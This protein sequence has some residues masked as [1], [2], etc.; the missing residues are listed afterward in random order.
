MRAPHVPSS[1]FATPLD[2]LLGA[3]LRVRV[4]RSLDEANDVRR[5]SDLA[6]LASADPTAVQRALVPLIA[7]GLVEQVGRGR[8]AVYR[9]R[10]DHP[11]AP[12][13]RAL[14]AAERGRR[15]AVPRAV[16]DWAERVE[17]G[18]LAVWL[19]GSV[20]RRD[21][22]FGSD[23]DL[24]LVAPG[25][26]SARGASGSQRASVTRHHADALADGLRA[27]LLPVAEA[28]HLSPNVVV[29]L[30]AELL[31]LEHRQPT[32]WRGLLEESEPVVGPTAPALIRRL[33]RD[34]ARV[35]PPL[36][37]HGPPT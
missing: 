32:M 16:R 26:G 4:L 7:S 15:A 12:P 25:P 9:V 6:R 5:A 8:G 11:F 1:A 28:T 35:Q 24:A 31:A 18:P 14:F 13:L 37:S 17:P 2:I 19:F 29:L 23:V 22:R 27:A 36:R 3:P 33:R 34:A 30:P 10:R 20:A 21:D